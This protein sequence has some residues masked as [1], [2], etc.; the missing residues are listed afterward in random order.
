MG[1][2]KNAPK[3]FWSTYV[4]LLVY[5]VCIMY[6][7]DKMRTYFSKTAAQQQQAHN[8]NYNAL[9]RVAAPRGS[10]PPGWGWG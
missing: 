3:Q 5:V 9:H 10:I 6:D 8:T 7:K 4:W 2:N 1:E